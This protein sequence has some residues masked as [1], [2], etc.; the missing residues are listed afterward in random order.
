MK[1]KVLTWGLISGVVISVL[2]LGTI[3][4]ATRIGFDKAEFVGYTVMVLSFLMVFF[5]IRSYREN[6]GGGKIS[7]GRAFARWR[8]DHSHHQRVLRRDLGGH[9]FQAHAKFLQ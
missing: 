9:V 6:V 5:G 2:M 7:F 4:F 8:S 3:P 1:K